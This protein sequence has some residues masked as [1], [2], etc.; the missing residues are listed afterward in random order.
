MSD[1]N[2]GDVRN[3]TLMLT[4]TTGLW[5]PYTTQVTVTCAWTVTQAGN[6]TPTFHM[7]NSNNVWSLYGAWTTTPD[8]TLTGDWPKST[9]RDMYNSV[10]FTITGFNGAVQDGTGTLPAKVYIYRNDHLVAE[11]SVSSASAISGYVNVDS[12]SVAVY[13]GDNIRID[14]GN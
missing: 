5:G 9:S 1:I 2:N 13:S 14:F 11:M 4:A 7:E 10:P 8:V 3:G 6:P 12:L